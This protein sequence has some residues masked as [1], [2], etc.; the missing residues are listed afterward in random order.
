MVGENAYVCLD[1]GVDGYC[2]FGG[3]CYAQVE[4]LGP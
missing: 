4:I 2:D 3:V 1:C